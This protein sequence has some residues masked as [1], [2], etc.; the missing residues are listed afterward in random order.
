MIM[1]GMSPRDE[2]HNL[3]KTLEKIRYKG[4]RHD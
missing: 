4:L 3:S 1:H 2:D